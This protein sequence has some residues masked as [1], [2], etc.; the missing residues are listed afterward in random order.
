MALVS[1][2]IPCYNA[3]EYIRKCLDSV[4]NQTIG[5]DNIEI[6]C[7]N[8]AS[9]DNTFNILCEY[10]TLYSD[11][12]IVINNDINTKPGYA[13]NLAIQYSTSDFITFVDSDDYVETN[14]LE[15]LYNNINNN[16][17]DFVMCRYYR[18]FNNKKYKMV[19]SLGEPL[20]YII[21]SKEDRKDLITKELFNPGSWGILYRK[22]FI[23][24][25]NIFFAE[26]IVYEDLVWLGLLPLYS[27][28]FLIIPDELYY[29]VNYDSSSI[30]TKKNSSHHFDRLTSMQIYLS[31]CK[32]R[33]LYDTFKNEI[34]WHFLEIFYINTLT[35]F[36]IRF[37]DAPAEILSGLRNVIIKELP[38]YKNNPYVKNSTDITGT[39]LSLLDKDIKTKTDW[40][41]ILNVIKEIFETK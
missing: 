41:N 7:I 37:D 27:S 29:Y 15:K 28:H 3:E 16:N 40:N 35:L 1:V 33:G 31:E 19:E 26:N 24:S 14:M 8:D 21:N 13:R 4:V 12:F 25:N 32:K 18:V 20:E 6:I 34:Q 38:D 36:S 30:I 5:I 17:Y 22:E 39:I 9:Q 10:E 2:I 23:I 11:S